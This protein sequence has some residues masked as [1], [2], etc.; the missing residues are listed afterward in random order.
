MLNFHVSAVQIPIPDLVKLLCG[1]Q[2]KEI[3]AENLSDQEIIDAA[4]ELMVTIAAVNRSIDIL[5]P[6]NI[7]QYFSLPVEFGV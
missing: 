6:G 5:H 3:E 2:M 1:P 4:S 7:T